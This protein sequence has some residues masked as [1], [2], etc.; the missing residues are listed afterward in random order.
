MFFKF[1]NVN[2]FFDEL[3]ESVSR[4]LARKSLDRAKHLA[5]SA[6]RNKFLSSAAQNETAQSVS[7]TNNELII[8]ISFCRIP[9]Y[10]RLN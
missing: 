2:D 10:I 1:I 4:T 7:S 3:Q 8:S 5:L 6:A 9:S